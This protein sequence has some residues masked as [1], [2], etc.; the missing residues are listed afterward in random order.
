MS[1]QDSRQE[2][3]ASASASLKLSLK[4]AVEKRASTVAG[5]RMTTVA[6]LCS[7]RNKCMLM[8]EMG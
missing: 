2:G 1:A 4:G 8:G 5:V 6:R 3:S 7:Y